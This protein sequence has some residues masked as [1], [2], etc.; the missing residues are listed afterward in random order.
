MII[1]N[2]RLEFNRD[3]EAELAAYGLV[4]IAALRELPAPVRCSGAGTQLVVEFG[5][6]HVR[7]TNHASRPRRWLRP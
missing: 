3:T 2:D 7:H 6:I 1:N 4:L 5:H